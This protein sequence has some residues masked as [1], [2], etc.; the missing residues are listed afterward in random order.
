MDG[1]KDRKGMYILSQRIRLITT[2]AALLLGLLAVGAV[3][4][5]TPSDDGISKESVVREINRHRL[6]WGLSP[7]RADERL[8]EAAE[9]R[10]IDMVT[11]GYWGHHCPDGHSTFEALAEHGYHHR[12]AGE[13][14]AAGYETTGILV[15]S[16]MESPGHRANILSSEYFDVG[17]A[18]ID[19]GTTRRMSGR[20]VVVLFAREMEED[21]ERE[22]GKREQGKDN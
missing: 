10:I 6:E 8:H 4:S 22:T 2:L 20:S 11:V 5:D 18:L 14:L 12:T 3:P 7:L 19:G 17:V 21:G 13:N 16:W 15:D 1:S 9:D